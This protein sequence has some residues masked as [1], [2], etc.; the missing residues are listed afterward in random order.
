MIIG[1]L[2]AKEGMLRDHW[3]NATKRSPLYLYKLVMTDGSEASMDNVTLGSIIKKENWSYINLEES[4][5]FS[6]N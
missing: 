2:T 6:N 4:L 3:N 1:N 5:P